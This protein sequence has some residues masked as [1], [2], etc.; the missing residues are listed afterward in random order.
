M[1]EDSQCETQG[2]APK[3]NKREKNIQQVLE[4]IMKNKYIPMADSAAT[5]DVYL[6]P[7]SVGIEGK[8]W[9]NVIMK[10]I[11]LGRETYV[12]K[13]A[14]TMDADDV[15]RMFYLA[16]M[17][18]SDNVGGERLL[19]DEWVF[20]V[21]EELNKEIPETDLS[22]RAKIASYYFSHY[23][24]MFSLCSSN[25]IQ[26]FFQKRGVKDYVNSD[27]FFR[28]I[29]ENFNICIGKSMRGAFEYTIT[30][31]ILCVP[32]TAD[33]RKEIEELDDVPESQDPL[34]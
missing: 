16:A 34:L 18:I 17:I 9:C 32:E 28:E 2:A 29:S 12:K 27:G 31:C 3:K 33:D 11:V 23:T 13:H 5:C 8:N 4:A 20:S 26:I 10:V 25:R 6:Q 1:R 22:E 24:P 14:F 21:F 19:Y 7:E 30:A 15:L